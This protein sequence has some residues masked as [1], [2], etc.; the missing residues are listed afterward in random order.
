M[1][2]GLFESLTG[3]FADGAKIESVGPGARRLRSIMD[4]LQRLFNT[5]LGS[6]SHLTDYGL[7]DISDIYRSMPHGLGVLRNA[8]RSTIDRYE[9]RLKNVRVALRETYSKDLRLSFVISAELSKGETV[10]FE[11]LFSDAGHSTVSPWRTL[12]FPT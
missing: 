3:A 8:I 10:R 7:P 1:Q 12:E 6:L 4:H 2:Q 11:T 5:R 9:P